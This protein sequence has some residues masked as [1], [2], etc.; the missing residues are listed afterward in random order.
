MRIWSTARSEFAYEKG[1]RFRLNALKREL[2]PYQRAAKI[3]RT[4]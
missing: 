2:Q 1:Q 3:K 4:Q